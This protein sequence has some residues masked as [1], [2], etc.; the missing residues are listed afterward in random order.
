MSAGIDRRTKKIEASQA[1]TGG[2]A[3]QR[4]LTNSAHE[5]KNAA[6]LSTCSTT[7]IE[8]TASIRHGS[9][10]SAST[11]VCWNARVSARRGSAAAWRDAMWMLSDDASTASVLAPRCARLYGHVSV[12]ATLRVCRSPKKRTNLPRIESPATPD[13]HRIQTCEHAAWL[14][15]TRSNSV[16]RR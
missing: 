16:R 1:R 5:R 15:R 12:K 11:D 13:V 10:T 7:S 6:G 9:C 14:K 2:G 4:T 8:Q 3:G